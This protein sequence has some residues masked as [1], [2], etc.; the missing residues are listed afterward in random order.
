MTTWRIA[1]ALALLVAGMTPL[2]AQDPV[3]ANP[4]LA[5]VPLT[6]TTHGRPHR[7]TVEVARTPVEQA[8]GLMVRRTM[9]RDHGMIF[10]MD[11]PREAGFWM[12][13]TAMPLDLVFIAPD[14]TVRRI[15]ANA[16]PYDR[17]MIPSNGIVAAV[18]ELKAGEAARIGLQ[19]GDAVGYTLDGPGNR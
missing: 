1:G 11:P 8:R 17:T 4:P 19:P 5:T 2:G 16:I 13:G 7:Y 14:R 18:L 10:P 15:A 12:E 9:P 6:V 3:V